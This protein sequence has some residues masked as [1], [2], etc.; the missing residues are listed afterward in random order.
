M[1]HIYADPVIGTTLA[2]K[3]RQSTSLSF[4]AFDEQ[5]DSTDVVINTAGVAIGEY[6]VTFESFNTLETVKSNLKID[7]MT[8]IVSEA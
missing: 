4:V 8:I 3:L 5:S 1:Q 2:I 7:T 6:T